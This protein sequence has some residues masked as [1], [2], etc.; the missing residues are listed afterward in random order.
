MAVAKTPANY[1]AVAAQWL[2][3][4]D[5]AVVQGDAKLSSR[6]VVAGL[7]AAR[8]G[9]SL[10]LAKRATVLYIQLREP[11]SDAVKEQARGRLIQFASTVQEPSGFASNGS[12]SNGSRSNGMERPSS[13]FDSPPTLRPTAADPDFAAAPAPSKLH[14]VRWNKTEN[15][16][17]KIFFDLLAAV[18]DF[19]MTTEG[20]KA[21]HDVLQSHSIDRRVALGILNEGFDTYCDWEQPSK[22]KASARMN[23]MEWVAQ[24]TRTMSEPMLTE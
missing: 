19:G 16:R 20:R 3:L 7:A 21:W 6:A 9:E 24:R 18:D 17:K 4:A 13:P 23:R 5:R 2:I 8:Q 15:E 10:E 14:E 12:K 11:P 22:G 1:R